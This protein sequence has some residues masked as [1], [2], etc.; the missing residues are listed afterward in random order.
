MN[1]EEIRT[2]AKSRSIKTGKLSKTGLIKSIQAGEGNF[3][4]YGTATQGVCDQGGCSWR[5]DCF[6]TSTQGELS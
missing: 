4:C 2:I 5:E 6:E 3:D 1:L